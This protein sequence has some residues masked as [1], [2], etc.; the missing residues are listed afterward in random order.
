M[1]EKNNIANKTRPL[2]VKDGK[3]NFKLS[4]ASDKPLEKMK[5]DEIVYYFNENYADRKEFCLTNLLLDIENFKGYSDKLDNEINN[6]SILFSVVSIIITC[7]GI[8][9]TFATDL[10]LI[11]LIIAYILIIVIFILRLIVYKNFP[12]FK[13]IVVKSVIYKLEA[14]KGE[15]ESEERLIGKSR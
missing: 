6:I 14:I 13:R 10:R 1:E 5:S 3:V 7:I 15:F 9:T 2:E 11:Y 8:L 4:F 12:G